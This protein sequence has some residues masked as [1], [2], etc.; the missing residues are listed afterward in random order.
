MRCAG[1]T[2]LQQGQADL[3]RQWAAFEAEKTAF[4]SEQ[5]SW[6]GDVADFRDCQSGWEL[7]RAAREATLVDTGD[8]LTTRDYQL[9]EAETAVNDSKLLTP[10]DF[11]VADTNLI[12][13]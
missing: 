7:E 2:K 9:E 11:T 1:L 13:T 4:M 5:A 10:Q 6:E 3:A 8:A 12:K